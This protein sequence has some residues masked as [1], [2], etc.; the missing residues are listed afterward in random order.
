MY[1]TQ[2]IN[3]VIESPAITADFELARGSLVLRFDVFSLKPELLQAVQA[4]GF[5]PKAEFHLT[6]IGYRTGAQL[7]KI[8]ARMPA[9]KSASLIAELRNLIMN[10]DWS[11]ETLPQYF[12]LKRQYPAETTPRESIIQI[13]ECAGAN[14]L[15]SEL[16][17][18]VP[19]QFFKKPPLHIT[20]ATRSSTDGIGI[21]TEQELKQYGKVFKL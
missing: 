14:R 21:S 3:F 4:R 19:G 13:A 7:K 2:D 12:Y 20:L 8:L 1:M 11:I 18:L 15:Y 10:I 16:T 17:H 5:R 9:A 6:I